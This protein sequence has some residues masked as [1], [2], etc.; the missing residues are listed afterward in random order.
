MHRLYAL[1]SPCRKAF[2]NIWN[3]DRKTGKLEYITTQT[4]QPTP[5]SG[6]PSAGG[7]LLES[8]PAEGCR[9]GGVGS[10]ASHPLN[11]LSPRMEL[12]VNA[13]KP[14]GINVRVNLRRG[15][16]G[17]AEHFLNDA[18]RRAVGQ[19]MAGE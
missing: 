17:V 5:A 15:D 1:P 11:A 3:N 12:T 14:V 9:N 6:H 19:Q 7:E 16:V 10:S 8:P 18:Q 2:S 13:F 4:P